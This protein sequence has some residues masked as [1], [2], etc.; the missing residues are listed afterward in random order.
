MDEKV[1]WKEKKVSLGNAI[2]V[3]AIVAFLC[4]IIGL[5]FN[6]WFGGYLPY[7]GVGGSASEEN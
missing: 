5:N 6:N 1:E 7:L 3:G 4:L 2:I